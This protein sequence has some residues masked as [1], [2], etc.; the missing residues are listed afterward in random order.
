MLISV[1]DTAG[2]NAEEHWG[3]SCV[4]MLFFAKKTVAK[5]E[6]CAGTLP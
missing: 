1:K 3:C 2:A 4:A 6:R 5:T